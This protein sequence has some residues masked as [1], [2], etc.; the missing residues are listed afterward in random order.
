MFYSHPRKALFVHIPKTG[1]SAIRD[2]LLTDFI[3][4]HR[5]HQSLGSL[6]KPKRY[7]NYFI[8]TIVRNPYERLVSSYRFN[9]LRQ[10]LRYDGVSFIEN[11]HREWVSHK[12]YPLP[13]QQYKY[14]DLPHDFFGVHVYK[15][16]HLQDASDDIAHR[17]GYKPV[18]LVRNETGNYHGEYDFR[19]WLD[20]ESVKYI[21]EICEGDFVKF[22]YEMW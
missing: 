19:D 10:N 5:K 9:K 7:S 22:G 3:K 12:N 20:E 14:I 17:L 6:K 21:N 18:Q 4:N 16:E 8:F 2:Q 13:H 11:L 1:G 15:Y